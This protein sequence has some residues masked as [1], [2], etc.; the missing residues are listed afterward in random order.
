MGKQDVIWGGV[1]FALGAAIFVMIPGQIKN[2]G[3]SAVGP[4]A[5]PYFLSVLLMICSAVLA[6]RSFIK[7]RKG[8]AASETGAAGEAV[9][10][11][12][13]FR[14]PQRRVAFSLGIF[15]LL[16]VYA[17]IMQRI[18]YVIAS[19]VFLSTLL[20][21]LGVRK[22][23]LYVL[24]VPIILIVYAVFQMILNVQLP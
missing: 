1:L 17:Q 24:M 13:G 3:G 10:G 18:G 21:L 14:A 4:R 20:Y 6:L 9:E 5:F 8:G 7:R 11:G 16:V 22:K 23:R 19:L 12:D 15:I 2:V